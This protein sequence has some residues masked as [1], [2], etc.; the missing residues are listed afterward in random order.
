MN[1]LKR[2]LSALGNGREDTK[3]ALKQRNEQAEKLTKA[4][5]DQAK[6]LRIFAQKQDRFSDD[7][8]HSRT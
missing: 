7:H 1:I 5:S 4:L 6:Q 3:E 2:M 8:H